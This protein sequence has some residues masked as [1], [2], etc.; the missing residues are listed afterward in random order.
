MTS[1][2]S[3]LLEESQATYI[4]PTEGCGYYTRI[5]GSTLYIF[6]CCEKYERSLLKEFFYHPAPYKNME[7]R[8]RCHY[9]ALKIW[10]AILPYIKEQLLSDK[11]KGI[12]ISGFGYGGAVAMLCHEYVYFNRPKLRAYIFGSAFG[13]PK[14]FYGRL[15]YGLAMRWKSFVFVNGISDPI[16]KSPRILGYRRVGKQLTIGKAGDTQ[17]S[18]A[19]RDI[20]DYLNDLTFV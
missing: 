4:Y 17:K 5:C 20:K 14:V 1:L 13:S 10:K 6:F 8:W 15:Q 2:Y 9:G 3:L 18:A 7:K 19:D 11:I 16:V 12:N